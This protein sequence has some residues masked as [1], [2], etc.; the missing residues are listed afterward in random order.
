[1]HAHMSG[2]EHTISSLHQAFA[3]P[4]KLWATLVC[5]LCR[6]R[7]KLKRIEVWLAQDGE[8]HQAHV[9]STFQA[10]MR[11]LEFR[12]D[13]EDYNYVDGLSLYIDRENGPE[14]RF[15]QVRV[16]VALQCSC[17]HDCSDLLHAYDVAN[18]E[19]YHQICML[20]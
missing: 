4:R 11:D 9:Q 5:L 17:G 18:A 10:Y 14:E 6:K 2:Y 16:D 1:M 8:P 13:E 7:S 20:S 3:K 15:E 12:I 19:L